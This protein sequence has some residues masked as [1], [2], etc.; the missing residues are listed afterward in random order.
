MLAGE[1]TRPQIQSDTIANNLTEDGPEEV[2]WKG[3]GEDEDR[4]VRDEER[5]GARFEQ[6]GPRERGSE[7]EQDGNQESHGDRS[8]GGE[9]GHP[10]IFPSH[11]A[12]DGGEE[13][14]EKDPRH[15]RVARNRKALGGKDRIEGRVAD[16]D[17]G[18]GGPDQEVHDSTEQRGSVIPRNP[19]QIG[20]RCGPRS[21]STEERWGTRV[22]EPRRCR[23]S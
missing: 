17:R 22:A 7:G 3:Q 18:H 8:E 2:D 5:Y 14:D 11:R 16:R 15:R 1:T 6:V 10:Q 23:G 13:Q 9:E 19:L 4:I 12:D 20:G 21:A